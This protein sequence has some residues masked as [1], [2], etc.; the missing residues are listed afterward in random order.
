M[1]ALSQPCAAAPALPAGARPP[2]RVAT[3]VQAAAS[4]LL[5]PPKLRER[6]ERAA[7]T[8]DGA[9]SDAAPPGSPKQGT[10]LLPWFRRPAQS[11][12]APVE[13]KETT[14]GSS[15]PILSFAGGGE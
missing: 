12:I 9:P 8:T 1:R 2:R 3:R 7:P 13:V 15:M 5:A 10:Q 14:G 11:P 6:L 4:P